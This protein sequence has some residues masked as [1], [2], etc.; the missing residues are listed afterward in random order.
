LANQ[1][2]YGFWCGGYSS[3]PRPCFQRHSYA[4]GMSPKAKNL[5]VYFKDKQGRFYLFI[6]PQGLPAMV[7]PKIMRNLVETS[8]MGFI[9]L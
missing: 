9:C 3:F 8:T 5:K 7:L 6:D 1:F 4:H 2:F